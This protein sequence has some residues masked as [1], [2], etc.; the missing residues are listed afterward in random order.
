MNTSVT[1]L[2]MPSIR[3]DVPNL[4]GLPD[5]ADKTFWTNTKSWMGSAQIG[6]PSYRKNADK[7]SADATVS[8]LNRNLSSV[9]F[10]MK[11][12]LTKEHDGVTMAT[13]H[14]NT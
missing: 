12:R 6:P 1:M 9:S 8:S 7:T 10:Y 2:S 14:N 5:T 13:A 11:A 3:F 4:E